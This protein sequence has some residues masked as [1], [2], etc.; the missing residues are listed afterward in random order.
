ML[1]YFADKETNTLPFVFHVFG[2][3]SYEKQLFNLAQRYP[4]HIIYYGFQSLDTIK[5]TA[6][7][8]DYCLM[9]SVCLETF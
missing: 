3:G 1:E 4:E 5:K 7:Q 8:C 9:P 2:K 6:E